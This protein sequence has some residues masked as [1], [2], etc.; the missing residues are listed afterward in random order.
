[1]SLEL[2]IDE[3]PASTTNRTHGKKRFD[4][5]EHKSPNFFDGEESLVPR[6]KIDDFKIEGNT[7][8]AVNYN[9]CRKNHYYNK[10]VL[11]SE[12]FDM[13]FP[14]D[15][16]SDT[17]TELLSSHWLNTD[18]KSDHFYAAENSERDISI[19]DSISVIGKAQDIFKSP[20]D[21]SRSQVNP[22]VE[23]DLDET[24]SQMISTSFLEELKDDDSSISHEEKFIQEEWEKQI[25]LQKQTKGENLDAYHEVGKSK[26][27]FSYTPRHTKHDV[28]YLFQYHFIEHAI[29]WLFLPEEP[30]ILIELLSDQQAIYANQTLSIIIDKMPEG[31]IMP[32][33][34]AFKGMI[35]LFV[36]DFT[37]AFNYFEK[38]SLIED[39]NLFLFWKIVSKFYVWMQTKDYE[40]LAILKLLVSKFERLSQFNVNVK[41]IRLRIKLYE[42]VTIDSTDFALNRA[43]DYALEIKSL[44]HSLGYIAMAEIY[45]STE[46]YGK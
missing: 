36:S 40:D 15:E 44:N 19:D 33:Y 18:M 6:L 16:D 3:A 29:D 46:Q 45:A 2:R 23:N 11:L 24:I 10:R 38:A 20:L 14:I 28:Y 17:D 41:W 25:Q 34:F 12:S 21:L 1:M 42:Y 31:E 4:M 5:P 39:N 7:S 30:E 13:N 8:Q 26:M 35:S 32:C 37:K 43:R 9:T 22:P 27:E